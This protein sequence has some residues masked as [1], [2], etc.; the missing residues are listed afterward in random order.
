MIT[1]ERKLKKKI[2]IKNET[3]NKGKKNNEKEISE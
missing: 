3:K 1:R 2:I